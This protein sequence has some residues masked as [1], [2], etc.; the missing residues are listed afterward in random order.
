LLRKALLSSRPNAVFWRRDLHVL[1]RIPY[2]VDAILAIL[3]ARCTISFPSFNAQ[4]IP[5]NAHLGRWEVLPRGLLLL[6]LFLQLAQ[7]RSSLGNL[8][9]VLD[10][11]PIEVDLRQRTKNVSLCFAAAEAIEVAKLGNGPVEVEDERVGE[12]REEGEFAISL[13]VHAGRDEGGVDCV[14]EVLG[15]VAVGSEVDFYDL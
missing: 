14:D 4:R 6:Q 9:A 7:L 8:D 3:L 5:P 11:I 1:E 12:S 10:P 13:T 15:F 2:E